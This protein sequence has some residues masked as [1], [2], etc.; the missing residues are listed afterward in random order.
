ML[1]S[2][3]VSHCKVNAVGIMDFTYTGTDASKEWLGKA[4]AEA[5]SMRLNVQN[6]VTVMAAKQMR[7]H[8][9]N[10]KKGNKPADVFSFGDLLDQDFLLSSEYSFY[11]DTLKLITNVWNV[12]KQSTNILSFDIYYTDNIFSVTDSVALA[13][14]RSISGDSVRL[15]SG[16][17]WPNVTQSAFAVYAVAKDHEA[18]GRFSEALYACKRAVELSSMF[19]EAQL[20]LVS[21]KLQ[22]G[23][24]KSAMKIIKPLLKSNPDNCRIVAAYGSALLASGKADQAIAF[25]KFKRAFCSE[26]PDF[27]EVFARAYLQEGFFVIAISLFI[28][29]I[30]MRPGFSDLY[31]SMGRAYY[32]SEEYQKAVKAIERAVA[33][34]PDNS[35]YR[36]WYGMACREADDKIR[37]IRILEKLSIDKPDYLP[38]SFQLAA[39]YNDLNWTKNAYQSLQ[40][41]LQEHPN[42]SELFAMMAVTLFKMGKMAEADSFF[43]KALKQASSSSMVLNN[44]GV[45]N[46]AAKNYSKAVKYLSKAIKIDKRNPGIAYNL[47]SAYFKLDKRKPAEKYLKITLESSP[48]HLAARRLMADIKKL[49]DDYEGQLLILSEI[50][51]LDPNDFDTKLEYARLLSIV[52]RKEDGIAIMEEIVKNNPGNI[53]YMIVLIN[54]Y[55]EIRWLD[56]AIIK[57]DNIFA[58]NPQNTVVAGLLG[59][60]I[61]MKLTDGGRFV[62][63]DNP[64]AL[65]ALY[66][67]KLAHSADPNRP[68]T[69]FWYGKALYEFKKDIEGARQLFKQCSRRGLPASIQKEI[70]A[71]LKRK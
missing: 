71:Y 52:G 54:A 5:L 22:S 67:L 63:K 60:L 39:T 45:Y 14:L 64:N 21:L 55:K 29:T 47:A 25:L 6:N 2:F 59:E 61:T 49:D 53:D 51:A 23:Q 36:C 4:I 24:H 41:P 19:V 7:L 12:R 15:A 44:F 3:S 37:A 16:F 70:D 33:L 30:T 13:V 69:L 43:S 46:L 40:R 35:N 9:I 28:K 57:L 8:R 56:V 58:K 1:L 65:K 18:H 26:D 20:L 68:E 27:S 10:H 31:Y 50:I 42:N 11:H 32:E 66:L 34:E 38:A 48:K 17:M 62:G